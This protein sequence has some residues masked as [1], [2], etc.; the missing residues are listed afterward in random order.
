MYARVF[1]IWFTQYVCVC[2]RLS[3]VRDS[4][5]IVKSQTAPH[6]KSSQHSQWGLQI[7]LGKDIV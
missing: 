3:S 1:L 5:S 7:A 2:K 6:R 4:I